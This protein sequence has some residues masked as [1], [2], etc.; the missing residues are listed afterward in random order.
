MPMARRGRRRF[1]LSLAGSATGVAALAVTN[2]E[3]ELP[4]KKTGRSGTGYQV[5]DHV[6]HYY[7]TTKV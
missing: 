5:T 7:R 2:K 6:R 1:F 4:E 3:A